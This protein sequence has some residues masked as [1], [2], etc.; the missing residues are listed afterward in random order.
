MRSQL[1]LFVVLVVL[2]AGASSWIL[3]DQ[4]D[5]EDISALQL[6]HELETMII[7]VGVLGLLETGDTEKAVRVLENRLDSSL[8]HANRIAASGV[9][10]EAA[11]PNL[12]ES[13]WRAHKYVQSHDISPEAL[14]NAQD[15]L[16]HLDAM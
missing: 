12:R 7:T 10:I 15:L 1:V 13:A 6:A 8:A 5:E 14:P 3:A 9:V 4:F 11:I 16:K 2:I